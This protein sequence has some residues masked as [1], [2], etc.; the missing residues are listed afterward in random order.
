MI[1]RWALPMIAFLGIGALAY[2]ATLLATPFALMRLAAAKAGTGLPLNE[3][4]FG[5]MTTAANQT[6]VRP[7]PD[8]S[9]SLCVFDVSNGPV[10]VRAEPIPG[11]YWSISIFDARTDVAAVRSDRDTGGKPALLALVRPG[12]QAPDGYEAVPVGY[13][14]GIVLIRILLA[15]KAEFA[16]IDALRQKSFCRAA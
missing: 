7:S 2:Q 3:F 13:D 16:T 5:P 4:R 12:Q 1:R 14:K 6:I 15:D 11:R 10:L 9:Y 8:L